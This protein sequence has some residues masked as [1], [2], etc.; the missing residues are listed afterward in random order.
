MVD[1]LMT[2]REA[3]QGIAHSLARRHH[4]PTP[5][6]VEAKGKECDALGA[7]VPEK[8]E[9]TWSLESIGSIFSDSEKNPAQRFSECHESWIQMQSRSAVVEKIAEKSVELAN[10]L[11][12]DESTDICFDGDK[13]LPC[14]S[15]TEQYDAE[16]MASNIACDIAHCTRGSHEKGYTLG[17]LFDRMPDAIE[18]V[19][20]AVDAAIEGVKVLIIVARHRNESQ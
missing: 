17:A 12:Q 15:L 18:M 7:Q 11:V 6:E 20:Q 3:T 19:G 16:T 13:A 4:L 10:Q 2:I 1:K 5:A 14:I 8:F 9:W